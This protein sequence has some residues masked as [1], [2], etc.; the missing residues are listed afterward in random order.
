MREKGP[1][2]LLELA[3]RVLEFP[4]DVQA[5]L[6]QLQAMGLIETQRVAGGQFGGELFTLTA[7]GERVLRLLSDPAFQRDAA[8]ASSPDTRRQE[9]ELLNKLG[10]VAKE[11]GN[12]Q[13]ALEYYEQALAI[14]RDLAVGAVNGAS[15]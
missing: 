9:A 15:I 7:S 3:V 5:P 13:K 10:D 11:Q 8:P 1:G 14:T 12:L 6:G 4:S 2:L